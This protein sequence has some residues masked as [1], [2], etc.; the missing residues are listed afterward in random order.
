MKNLNQVPFFGKYFQFNK[1]IR[2]GA[3]LRH[4]G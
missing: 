3:D 1:L 4:N 2:E